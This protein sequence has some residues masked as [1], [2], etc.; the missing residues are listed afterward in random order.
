VRPQIGL[1]TEF[2]TFL[3]Q[4]TDKSNPFADET[5]PLVDSTNYELW[6]RNDG[7][8]RADCQ[9]GGFDRGRIVAVGVRTRLTVRAAGTAGLG[10]GSERLVDDGLDG[11]RTA[12]A[13]GAAAEATI[14]LLGVPGQIFRALD[15]TADIVIGQDVTG[16]NNHES[17]ML[18]RAADDQ[19]I[20]ETRG[21][22]K[23]KN[24]IFK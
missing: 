22:C 16:T 2:R 7:Q 4:F 3:N 15:S 24:P 18:I 6:A 8:E 12:A 17:G 23:R 5:K 11:A 14:E 10:A 9:A 13:F 21:G 19:P 20:L 1:V